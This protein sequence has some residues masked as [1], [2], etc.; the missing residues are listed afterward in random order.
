[1]VMEATARRASAQRTVGACV[2]LT[3]PRFIE[4]LYLML[5]FASMAVDVLLRHH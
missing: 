3:K 4:L 1:M 5:L 2:A